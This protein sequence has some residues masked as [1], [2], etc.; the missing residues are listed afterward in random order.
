MAILFG[1]D[2]VYTRAYRLVDNIVVLWPL[3]P[4]GHRGASG[5]PR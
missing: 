3:Q 1:L 5:R 4:E 2:V